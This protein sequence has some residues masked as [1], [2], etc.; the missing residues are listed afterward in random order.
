MRIGA[1]VRVIFVT[2]LFFANAPV[3][4]QNNFGNTA[5]E[6]QSLTVVTGVYGK[7]GRTRKL[8]ISTQLRQLCGSEASSC[9]VFCSETTF[10]RY[11]LGRHPICRVTYRCGADRVRSVEA[12]K[13]EPIIMQCVPPTAERRETAPEER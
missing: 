5:G 1:F 13:E 8:D 6:R 4:A 2:L 9:T 3:S 11:A 10:G 12:A 7:L